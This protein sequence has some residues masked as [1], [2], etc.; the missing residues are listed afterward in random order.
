MKKR[1]AK[2]V[3]TQQLALCAMLLSLMLVL[4]WVETL[5]P[6]DA[7]VPGIKLGLSN[8]VLVFAVYL[9]PLSQAWLLMLLKVLLSG[10][11]FGN[12][13]TMMYAAA[14]GVLSLGCMTLL[15][16]VKG[17]HPVTVSIV[18]G[19]AHNVGQVGLAMLILRTAGLLGYL[20]ILIPVGMG[21]GALC[22]VAAAGV[23]KA[24]RR[25]NL[26][27]TR[28]AKPARKPE[29]TIAAGKAA[30]ETE[31]GKAAGSIESTEP[32]ES[33]EITKPIDSPESTAL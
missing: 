4:G 1:S 31:A 8:G 33:I 26:F 17:M 32:T 5:I 6:L 22:G 23:M 19:A 3:T 29:S 15:S 10:F 11:L 21:C 20:G 12:P 14:G 18:G 9:L 7:A 25:T 24:A 2:T 13:S 30:G 28:A 16:R 27:D